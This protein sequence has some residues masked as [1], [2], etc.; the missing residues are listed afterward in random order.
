MTVD[1]SMDDVENWD[2]LAH[3]RVC[4]ALEDQ[5]GISIPLETVGEL[6]SVEAIV[7]FLEAAGSDATS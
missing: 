4:M 3:L 1:A 7:A 6:T 2:S 5:F